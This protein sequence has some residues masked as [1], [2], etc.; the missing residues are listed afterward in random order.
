MDRGLP[1]AQQSGGLTDREQLRPTTASRPGDAQAKAASSASSALAALE[2][3]DSL[4]QP[5]LDALRPAPPAV[6]AGRPGRDKE[7]VASA[8]L[9]PSPSSPASPA[10]L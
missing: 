5:S 9:R 6:L 4:G 8:S 1:Q 3:H 7:P 10:S 2:L